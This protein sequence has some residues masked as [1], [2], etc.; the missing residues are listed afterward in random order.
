MYDMGKYCDNSVKLTS[1]ERR[2]LSKSVASV[3]YVLVAGLI[4]I[5]LFLCLVC[6]SLLLVGGVDYTVA[7]LNARPGEPLFNKLL[8]DLFFPGMIVSAFFCIIFAAKKLEKKYTATGHSDAEEN[9][10]IANREA[11]T[12]RM[13]KVRNLVGFS[14]FIPVLSWLFWVAIEDDNNPWWAVPTLGA[15]LA[16]ML[17]MLWRQFFAEKLNK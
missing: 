13:E 17:L 14:F 11:P 7:V 15:V 8:S 1:A 10:I 5:L 4:G 2:F 16:F 12:N 9:P 6:L 3:F